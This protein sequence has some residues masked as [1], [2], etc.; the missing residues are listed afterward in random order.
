MF[1]RKRVSSHPVT[2]RGIPHSVVFTAT[3]HELEPGAAVDAD[4]A[5]ARFY[6]VLACNIA[7]HEG[8][9][10]VAA[11]EDLVTYLQRD[12]IPEVKARYEIV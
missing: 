2:L 8:E 9:C 6:P 5:P 7:D 10:I 4:G 12:A 3:I 1:G 11:L